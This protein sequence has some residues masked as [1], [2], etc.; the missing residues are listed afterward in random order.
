MSNK[1]GTNSHAKTKRFTTHH[2]EA[3]G[4]KFMT[5]VSHFIRIRCF[6]L[7]NTQNQIL[8]CGLHKSL[9]ILFFCF[10]ITRRLSTNQMVFYVITVQ[11]ENYEWM[12]NTVAFVRF[13][14]TAYSYLKSAIC[15]SRPV[16]FYFVA[17]VC[18]YIA[19]AK[20][21]KKYS[22]IF[23]LSLLPN[24]NWIA[25]MRPGKRL[26]QMTVFSVIHFRA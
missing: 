8:I 20:W 24:R 14:R 1:S 3:Q 26:L 2:N 12:L 11:R 10:S 18:V 6:I 15:F 9:F 22:C 25:W 17:F 5:N 4:A 13:A 19:R 16:V 7:I 21:N 23:T